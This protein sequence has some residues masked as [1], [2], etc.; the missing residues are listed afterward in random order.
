MV[1]LQLLVTRKQRENVVVITVAVTS[2]G[3]Q[4]MYLTLTRSQR[5]GHVIVT[6]F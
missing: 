3:Y 5:Y 6:L 1:P 2:P 4:L